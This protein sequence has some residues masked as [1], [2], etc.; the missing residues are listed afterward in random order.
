MNTDDFGLSAPEVAERVQAFVRFMQTH[1]GT[2]PVHCINFIRFKPSPT[3]PE[4]HPLEASGLSCEELYAQHWLPACEATG[5]AKSFYLGRALPEAFA[6]IAAPEDSELNPGDWDAV[7]IVEYA[8]PQAIADL[9]TSD[10][11]SSP[12][13][14]API[15]VEEQRWLPFLRVETTSPD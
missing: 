3:Y 8:N 1:E 13:A 4:G 9:M 11:F 7:F 12:E 5:F 15:V 2:D 6:P 14:I 10:I